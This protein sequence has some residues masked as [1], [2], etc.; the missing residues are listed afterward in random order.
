MAFQL[1]SWKAGPH[2]L[3]GSNVQTLTTLKWGTAE[4]SIEGL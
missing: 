1:Y 3:W 2:L 4:G